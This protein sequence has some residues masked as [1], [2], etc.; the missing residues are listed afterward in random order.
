MSEGKAPWEVLPMA[1][2]VQKQHQTFING[3]L[4]DLCAIKCRGFSQLIRNT[5]YLTRLMKLSNVFVVLVAAAFLTARASLSACFCAL[6]RSLRDEAQNMIMYI[7]GR[8]T[9]L[10]HRLHSADNW[11]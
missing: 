8:Q 11:T 6:S 4:P 1:K 2:A 10:N 7:R 3:C 5:L 9:A